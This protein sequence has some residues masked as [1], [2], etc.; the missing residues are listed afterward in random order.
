[1]IFRP[2][3]LGLGLLCAAPQLSAAESSDPPFCLVQQEE[4]NLKAQAYIRSYLAIAIEEMNRSGIPA[5]ITLA[6]GMLESNY[7]RSEL[8]RQANN[9]FGI[10]CGKDWSG[11]TYYKNT[12][13]QTAYGT[14]RTEMACFRAYESVEDSYKDHTNF[15]Y[16]RKPYRTLFAARNMDYRFWAKG[17][18]EANYATDVNY[19][20]KL[21]EVIEKFD[22]AQYDRVSTQYQLPSNTDLNAYRADPNLDMGEDLSTVRNRVERLENSLQ[23]ALAHEIELQ[24]QLKEMNRQIGQM[25]KRDD[26][27]NGKINYVGTAL[28]E[29]K[30]VIEELQIEL[31][32]VS[33]IQRQMLTLDPFRNY[34]DP[35]T[36]MKKQLVI[37]PTQHHNQKGVFYKNSRRA[38]TL[39]KGMT[40]DDI[41]QEHQLELKSLRRY[42]DLSMG[43]EDNLPPN[44]Y[45]Y[46][47]AKGNMVEDE[48]GPHK[49]NEGES[50]YTISQL[51]GIKLS[52]L[53]KRNRLEEGEEPAVNEFIFLNETCD[54]KPALRG[55]N[56]Y[57]VGENQPNVDLFGGG[58]AK[59]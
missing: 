12:Q 50:M 14:Q 24:V 3:L 49:V 59:K 54:N 46:L 22:L 58:G 9:H 19:A 33:S 53:Y 42:N 44:C 1:M 41:A 23:Q 6:Q 55:A 34:F 37:F 40:L 30:E 43:E 2:L 17:L 16:S 4:E 13:E 52:K 47:E 57:Q 32:T 15:L 21:I 56:P 10:K 48:K 29:Q 20:N 5:S 51:Y 26:R 28:E 8:A 39:R 38:T 45:I 31:N 35:E 11:I 7:G 36:G 27:L 18:K 25:A